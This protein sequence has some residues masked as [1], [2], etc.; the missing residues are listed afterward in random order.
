[1]NCLFFTWKV[2]TNYLWT[3]AH[4]EKNLTFD[5]Q[6]GYQE[7][8]KLLNKTAELP[9]MYIIKIDYLKGKNFRAY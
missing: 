8:V 1:M 9:L 5:S 2:S 6:A 7:T 3:L 4:F